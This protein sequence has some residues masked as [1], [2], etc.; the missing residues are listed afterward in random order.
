[1]FDGSIWQRWLPALVQTSTR[2]SP[3]HPLLS[4]LTRQDP[5]VS[6][7]IRQWQAS[8]VTNCFRRHIPGPFVFAGSEPFLWNIPSSNRTVWMS[9]GNH[10]MSVRLIWSPPLKGHQFTGVSII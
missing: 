8:S 5:I 2:R 6:D 10:I 4:I 7:V 9:H 1:M 3:E